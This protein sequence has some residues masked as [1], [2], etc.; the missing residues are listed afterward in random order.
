MQEINPLYIRALATLLEE[1]NR[2]YPLFKGNFLSGI[3]TPEKLF[4]GW[5]I[6]VTFNQVMA[7]GIYS[8]S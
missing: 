4:N 8:Y 6:M 3:H 1:E 7:Q 2:L 5:K